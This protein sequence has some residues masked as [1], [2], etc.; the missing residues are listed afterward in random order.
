MIDFYSFVHR[1]MLENNTR[2]ITSEP[3]NQRALKAPFT[4]V[5]YTDS[6]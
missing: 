6:Y 4:C 1:P 5:V 2:L 3:A